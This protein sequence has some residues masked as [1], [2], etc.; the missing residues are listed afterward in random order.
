M[1]QRAQRWFKEYTWGFLSKSHYSRCA[2]VSTMFCLH[3]CSKMPNYIPTVCN[4]VVWHGGG[5]ADTIVVFKSLLIGTWIYSENRDIDYVQAHKYFYHVHHD[6]NSCLAQKRK[7]S[8]K[9]IT[10]RVLAC[11][12]VCTHRFL[13]SSTFL[14]LLLCI[15][16]PKLFHLEKIDTFFS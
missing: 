11:W 5:W 2:T 14:N 13:C 3:R 9:Q 7:V 12:W 6:I 8:H 16:F 1:S 15:I 10:W 4:H